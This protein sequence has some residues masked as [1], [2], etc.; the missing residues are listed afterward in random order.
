MQINLFTKPNK[1][2]P[3]FRYGIPFSK[4]SSGDNHPGYL[5]TNP[6]ILIRRMADGESL[7]AGIKIHTPLDLSLLLNTDEYID[8]SYM[9]IPYLPM[10]V[11]LSMYGDTVTINGQPL[12]E[13]KYFNPLSWFDDLMSFS[14][15][16]KIHNVRVSLDRETKRLTYR[17]NDLLNREWI[18]YFPHQRT[19]TVEKGTN[20][21]LENILSDWGTWVELKS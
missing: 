13:H 12:T 19:I 10:Q 11:Y 15:C 14:K 5:L 3:E 2:L 1:D 21:A 8:N 9:K 18:L 6:F 16:F 17:F 20:V 4:L 7:P